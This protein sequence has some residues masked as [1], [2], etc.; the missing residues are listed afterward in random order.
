MSNLGT[1]DKVYVC[2]PDCKAIKQDEVDAP[3]WWEKPVLYLLCAVI[4]VLAA[5]GGLDIVLRILLDYW[6]TWL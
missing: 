1:T 4:G 5:I 2:G 3:S 6:K